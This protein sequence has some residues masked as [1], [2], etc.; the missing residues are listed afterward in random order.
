MPG[1]RSPTLRIRASGEYAIF[2]RP[3]LKTERLTYSVPTPSAVRGIFEAI[4]WKPAICWHIERI[5]V[6]NEIRSCAIKRNE[7]ST[8]GP[9]PT[10]ATV[11]DG[12]VA[13]V[14]WADQ[15]KNRAQ[16]NT[17]ALRD[18]DYVFEAH[19]SLTEKAGEQDNV[20]KFVAMFER[21]V[22]KGQHYHQPYFGCREC[23]ARIEPVVEEPLPIA[24]SRDLGIMLWDVRFGETK[25]EGNTPLF[26]HARMEQ[27]MIDVPAEP[28]GIGEETP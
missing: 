12:G 10:A 6:L 21:R 3:E 11:R 20:R 17:V 27:G 24:E 19:F 8:K 5:K 14:Y 25:R 23:V 18:V 28:I 16:R 15:G 26:F 13:P 2:T 1:Q 7:V 4:L 9:M 22:A